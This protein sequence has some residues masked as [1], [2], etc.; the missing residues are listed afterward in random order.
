MTKTAFRLP[1]YQN[2]NYGS[3]EANDFNDLQYR[4]SRGIPPKDT[5]SRKSIEEALDYLDRNLPGVR[6]GTPKH[7]HLIA[8]VSSSGRPLTTAK[9]ICRDYINAGHHAPEHD[10]SDVQEL[11][12]KVFKRQGRI[13][14]PE[15]ERIFRKLDCSAIQGNLTRGDL[16]RADKLL[17]MFKAPGKRTLDRNS[18]LS[19][20]PI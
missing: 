6:R 19:F 10:A 12:V 2:P 1:H 16:D 8:R 3:T 7:E 20:L 14:Y 9:S 11:W 5:A 15:Q 17:R 13:I 18:R 4:K